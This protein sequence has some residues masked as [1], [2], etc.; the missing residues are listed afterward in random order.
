[1]FKLTQFK[2]THSYKDL[3]ITDEKFNLIFI[4]YLCVDLLVFF[5]RS[6][7]HRKQK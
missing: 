2:L 4:L 3:M 7:K 6:Y 5:F 1:M